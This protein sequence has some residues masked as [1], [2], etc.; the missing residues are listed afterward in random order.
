M[1]PSRKRSLRRAVLATLGAAALFG[2]GVFSGCATNFEAQSKI[3]TLRV[4]S[5]TMDKPYVDLG[6]P[7]SPASEED[8]TVHFDME[9]HDGYV[10]EDG[11]SRP[12]SILWIGGCFNPEGDQYSLCVGPLIQIFEAA[13]AA[14]EAD[15]TNPGF[16]PGLPVGVGTKFSIAVPAD[17]VSSR[18]K[19]SFG[20][21][22]GLG[23]VFFLACAGHL[24]TVVDDPSAA[25]TFPIG[26]L[27]DDGQPVGSD[28]FVPGYTQ[29]YAFEDG[30]LNANPVIT[31]MS[32]DGELMPEDAAL[33]PSVPLCDVPP[34]DRNLPPSCS[35]EDPFVACTGYDVKVEVPEDVAELDPEA[36]GEAGQALKEA[37]WVDYYTDGGDFNG[38]I[39]LVSE[40]TSG[41]SDPHE[42]KWIPPAEPGLATIWAVV[43]DA[44]GGSSVVVRQVRVE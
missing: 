43:H 28:S 21:H 8:R 14:Y 2:P 23:Y 24:K 16:P 29:I 10:A 11:S 37:V 3:D 4:I 22:Y 31:G 15:P 44:R 42:V 18:P 7:E 26:C 25:G 27:D 9:L 13:K 36:K 32:L 6:T 17:L 38:D 30:R 5:V 41:Y 34:Q 19:P 20:P 1:M 39:K 33:A 40:P 35:R 12:I